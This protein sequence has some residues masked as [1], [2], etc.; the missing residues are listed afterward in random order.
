LKA[1][2]LRV[3]GGEVNESLAATPTGVRTERSTPPDLPTRQEQE[4]DCK[5]GKDAGH[6]NQ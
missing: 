4:E 5:K 6:Q 1:C 2:S 3:G